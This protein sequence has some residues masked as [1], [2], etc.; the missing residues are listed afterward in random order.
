MHAQEVLGST[1]TS[2]NRL[3]YLQ[4]EDEVINI[5]NLVI[6]DEDT[7]VKLAALSCKS[8]NTH[9]STRVHTHSQA[10]IHTHIFPTID[11]VAYG[12]DF[13]EDAESIAADEEVMD[14]F[15]LS[16]RTKKDKVLAHSP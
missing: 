9:V 16:W 12:P 7:A 8:A 4:A 14:F 5:G 1:Q 13:P 11:A 15:P 3:I 6:A 2:T 10:P